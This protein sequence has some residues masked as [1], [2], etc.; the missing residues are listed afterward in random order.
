MR[1]AMDDLGL[2]R[3]DVIHIGKKTY[4]L[5]DRVRAVAFDRME[6]DVARLS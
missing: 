1:I 4:P 6:L 5:A 3:L 2:S